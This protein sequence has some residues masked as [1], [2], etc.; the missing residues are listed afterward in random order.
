MPGGCKQRADSMANASPVASSR[1]LRAS[2][3]TA[4]SRRAKLGCG[5]RLQPRART[6]VPAKPTPDALRAAVSRKL[7]DILPPDLGVLLVG[8]NPGLY[9]AAIGHHFGRPG[10]RFWKVLAASGLT[11]RL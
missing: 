6:N 4:S 8:I 5:A 9:S 3:T 11:P 2:R 7:P 10:N 1:P